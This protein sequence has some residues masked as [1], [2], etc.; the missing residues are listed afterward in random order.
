[1]NHIIIN[2]TKRHQAMKRY[3]KQRLEAYKSIIVGLV[4]GFIV[5]SYLF[6]RPDFKSAL[7]TIGIGLFFG[8]VIVYPR[9]LKSQKQKKS[10]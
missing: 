10:G 4:F 1:M 8:E 9:W 3:I 5:I 6:E 2:H 7:L